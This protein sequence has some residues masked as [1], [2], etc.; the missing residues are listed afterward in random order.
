MMGEEPA[1]MWVAPSYGLKAWMDKGGKESQVPPV[2][3]C[4]QYMSKQLLYTPAT[5]NGAAPAD[6]L[7]LP[8]I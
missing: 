7:K 6:G 8:R 4:L 2:F 3:L 5:Q 1:L